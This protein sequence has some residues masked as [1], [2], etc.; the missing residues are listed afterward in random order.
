M[1]QLITQWEVKEEMEEMF[2]LYN[3]YRHMRN[4]EK[5]NDCYYVF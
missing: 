3:R 5:W 2:A 1:K 4:Y